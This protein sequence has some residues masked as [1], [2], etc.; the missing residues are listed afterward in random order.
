MSMT[1]RA[2]LALAS[3]WPFGRLAVAQ[4]APS[5]RPQH[6]AD[7]RLGEHYWCVTIPFE[8]GKS[9]PFPTRLPWRGRLV[10]A[11]WGDDLV[12]S[13]EP[14]IATKVNPRNLFRTRAEAQAA[15]VWDWNH[16]P[17]GSEVTLAFAEGVHATLSRAFEAARVSQGLEDGAVPG[18]HVVRFETR[19]AQQLFATLATA[20]NCTVLPNTERDEPAR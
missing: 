17:G 20:L 16:P 9:R 11:A 13:A 4:P 18:L 7:P 5:K 15:I 12:L 1:R 3:L 19:L 6:V 8:M 2:W 14:Y 10:P